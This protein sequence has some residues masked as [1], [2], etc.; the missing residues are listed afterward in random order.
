MLDE[1]TNDDINKRVQDVTAEAMTK[2][3]AAVSSTGFKGGKTSASFRKKEGLINRIG[4]RFPRALVFREKGAGKG[5]GGNKG[6]QWTNDRGEKIKTNPKSL[7]KMNTGSRRAKPLIDPIIDDFCEELTA[8]VA[9]VFVEI[10][11]KN[12]KIK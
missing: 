8:A 10:S 11:F 3:K 6:S 12:I 9:D 4:F 1:E 7:G 5:K 2:M